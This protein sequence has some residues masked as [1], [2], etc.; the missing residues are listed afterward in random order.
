MGLPHKKLYVTNT[1]DENGK[2][3]FSTWKPIPSKDGYIR[4]SSQPI[5]L[6]M[7]IPNVLDLT[8]EEGVVPVKIVESDKETGLWLCCY[9]DYFG[10]EQ[11]LFNYKPTMNKETKS[12]DWNEF[13]DDDNTG[14]EIHIWSE[15]EM[16]AGDGPIPVTLIRIEEFTE[17]THKKK[18]LLWQIFHL[19]KM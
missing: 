9:D 15:I 6:D 14:W 1:G 8:P 19:K 16:V 2:I 4:D 17:E 13:W 5:G 11:H 3:F 18:G 12:I 7:W 10:N